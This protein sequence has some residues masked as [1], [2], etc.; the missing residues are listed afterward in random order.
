MSLHLGHNKR[1]RRPHR[2]R[3]QYDAK[4]RRLVDFR[5]ESNLPPWHTTEV[6]KPVGKRLVYDTHE[7]RMVWVEA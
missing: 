5:R 3:Q 1:R 6:E 2:D 4:I 7:N